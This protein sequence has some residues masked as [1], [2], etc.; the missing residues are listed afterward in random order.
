MNVNFVDRVTAF[1]MQQQF[2]IVIV[3]IGAVL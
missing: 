3:Q 1:S 2:T